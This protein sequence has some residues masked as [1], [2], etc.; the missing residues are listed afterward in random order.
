[1]TLHEELLDAERFLPFD[2]GQTP[3]LHR[4]SPQL[5]HLNTVPVFPHDEHR[6]AMV[7]RLRGVVEDAEPR[8]KA[9]GLASI[10]ENSESPAYLHGG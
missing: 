10:K 5:L 7:I 3:L 6:I 8:R 4:V 1:M 2:P 9:P